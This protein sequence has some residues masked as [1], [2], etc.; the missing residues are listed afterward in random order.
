MKKINLK[1]P[2]LKKPGRN[3][4]IRICNL[5]S[6]PLQF[7]GCCVL[8][9]V[10]EA[11]SRHSLFQAWNYMTESPLIFLYNA[12]LIFTTS[13]VVYL[14]R[15][16]ILA[17]LIVGSFW[18]ILG[19][20]NGFLLTSRVTPFTGPDLKLITDAIRILN[21]YLSPV[22][23]VVV[24]IAI[25]ALLC[26]FVWMFRKGWKF[27][28]KLRYWVNIPLILVGILA[29]AGT[30]RLALEKR[31]L[32][33]YF[34]NIAYAYQDYGY[35]Y[36]LAVTLFDTGISEPTGYSEELMDEIVESEG[37]I[38]ATKE[39]NLDVNI[40]FLQLETF[41]DPTE[42]NFLEFS[43][44]PIPNFRKLMKK[45]SSG[46]YKVPAV[47]AG[48][49]NTEF[50]SITGMSLR[51]FGAGEYPYKSILKETTCES[52]PYVLKNLGYATHAI[53]NNEAN[54]YG[55]RSVFSRLG[56]DTFTSEEYMPDISDTTPMGWVKDHILT[57]EIFKAMESTQGPDYVYTISVQ[58]HGDYPT[59]PMLSDPTIKVTGAE[60]QEMN[61]AWEYYVN[62]LYEMDQFIKELTDRLKEFD[63]RVVLVMYG[64]HLPTMDLKV[65][66][67]KNRYLFQTKYVM[68]SNFKMKKKDKNLA[69]YQMAA[70]VFNRL[71]IH[72]GNVFNYH[73]TR[74]GTRNYQL[75]LQSL[76]YDILYGD[77]Y[78]YGGEN[79]FSATALQLGIYPA[80]FERIEP[81]GGDSYFVYGENFTASSRLEVN[82]EL[83]DT[84]YISPTRLLVQNLELEAGAELD[85]AM[86]SNSS[87]KKVLSR[88]DVQIYQ[89]PEPEVTPE[90]EVSPTGEADLEPETSP[91]GEA[92]P[93]PEPASTPEP[94]K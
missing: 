5:L 57:D 68:W 17:R 84:K 59:E 43:E 30:T 82:G 65:E 62:Q 20:V 16:R 85:V 41:I 47:G 33:N 53:H 69:A 37:E 40:L 61:Y 13:L 24:L 14:V 87:T 18:F 26:S 60:S 58:G 1:K 12:F 48:T 35:P 56:F 73:Q 42:I 91:T 11:L 2:G 50:E 79:P 54:F 28:G 23:V 36:C 15:R 55:R 45:Y 93:A 38:K 27:Q 71:G 44:D 6:V 94:E 4:I 92:T 75:D 46:Y 66:D 52:A 10:I 78:V 67:M 64:D 88:T 76:Q 25:A 74:K 49:A 29:F 90:P 9:L 3:Q 19:C 8:Y 70:E 81:A 22:M 34:G 83:I 86:Q 89:A 63:E 72:E 21:K 51:Y 39:K 77:R 7:L 31:I 80:V 32:S